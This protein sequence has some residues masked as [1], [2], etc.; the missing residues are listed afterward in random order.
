MQNVFTCAPREA[1]RRAAF[2]L[3][4][5]VDPEEN[6]HEHSWTSS[7]C[8]SPGLGGP[9]GDHVL[10]LLFFEN[11]ITSFYRSTQTSCTMPTW[12]IG[13]SHAR[14]TTRGSRARRD[15]QAANRLAGICMQQRRHDIGL[16][17]PAFSGARPWL[18]S[19]WPREHESRTSKQTSC[20]HVLVWRSISTLLIS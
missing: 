9:H 16:D 20:H 12:L 3:R 1:C 14:P 11:R 19:G 15:L 4:R 17:R 7:I 6:V 5:P 2:L 10:F 13:P 18:V 8:S